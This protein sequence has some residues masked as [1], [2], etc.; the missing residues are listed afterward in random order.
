MRKDGGLSRPFFFRTAAPLVPD[1]EIRMDVMDTRAKYARKRTAAVSDALGYL[2]RIRKYRFYS[3]GD[4]LSSEGTDGGVSSS[5]NESVHE[6]DKDLDYPDAPETEKS[7]LLPSEDVPDKPVAENDEISGE[8]DK[9]LDN[10]YRDIF[11]D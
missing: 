10:E 7:V 2:D 3:S 8:R 9:Y 5:G 6:I 11:S 4:N 1:H